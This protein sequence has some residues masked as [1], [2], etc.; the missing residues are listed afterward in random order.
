MIPKF[1]YS[2]ANSLAFKRSSVG[3]DTDFSLVEAHVPRTQTVAFAQRPHI[4]YDV[5]GS[6]ADPMVVYGDK[7]YYSTGRTLRVIDGED[8]SLLINIG[9][10]TPF[11]GQTGAND[12]IKGMQVLSNGYMLLSTGYRVA[13]EKGNLYYST[14]QGVTWN[15]CKLGEADFEFEI[16][17][18]Q[19]FGML[20]ESGGEVL[21]GEYGETADSCRRVYYSNDYGINWTKIFEPAATGQHLHAVIW[22]PGTT[23]SFYAAY[24]DGTANS[25]VIRV[26][27]IDT[28]NKANIASWQKAQTIAYFN[29]TTAFRRGS[30]LYWGHDGSGDD[31]VVFAHDTLTETVTTSLDWPQYKANAAYAYLGANPS[32][33]IYSMFEYM[34]VVYAAVRDITDKHVSGLYATTDMINWVCIHRAVGSYGYYKI[35]GYANGYIW[36]EFADEAQNRDIYKFE[37]IQVKNYEGL[38]V[39]AAISNKFG[40]A[41]SCFDTGLGGWKIQTGHDAVMTLSSEKSLASGNSA[42]VVGANNSKGFAYAYSPY[43]PGPTANQYMLLSLWIYIEQSWPKE[44]TIY[45]KWGTAGGDDA[46]SIIRITTNIPKRVPGWQKISCWAKAASSVSWTYGPR[47]VIEIDDNG[48]GKFTDA[49][50]YIGAAQAVYFD[51]LWYDGTFQLGGTD[52]AVE[53]AAYPLAGIG[54]EYSVSINWFPNTGYLNAKRDIALWS[55]TGID[56]SYIDIYWSFS[57]QK[58]YVTDGTNSASTSQTYPFEYLDL[59]KIAL[60]SDGTDS[61]LYIE[62]SVNGFNSTTASLV[63]LTGSPV[64]LTPG[65]TNAGDKLQAGI[66]GMARAYNSQLTSPQVQEDF[67]SLQ[68]I[69][70][71]VKPALSIL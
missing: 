66:F 56:G 62:D 30:I 52:R 63:N 5:T 21:L 68:T 9:S 29:P 59:I 61:V 55:I 67:N 31:P 35:I 70:P 49:V 10:S 25:E 24:G 41:A 2:D 37:P 13:G 54:T 7:V 58:I 48:S 44:Y 18:A 6:F 12:S 39:E 20:A 11:V 50:F 65:N 34:G 32:G 8:N 17:F 51:D 33:D 57:D 36:G 42:K 45:V 60:T 47:A 43:L 16:G 15:R 46:S 14:N 64:M 1:E 71:R 3:Y 22:K 38:F 4:T 69:V 19:D 28:A 53:K 23:Q 26:D 27:C 40:Q